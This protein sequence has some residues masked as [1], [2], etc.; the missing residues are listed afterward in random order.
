MDSLDQV[1]NEGYGEAAKYYHEER[2]EE[3]IEKNT[4]E[5]LNDPAVPLYPRIKLL[6]LP[7]AVAEDWSE[8]NDCCV[9]AEGLR[10]M[11]RNWNSVG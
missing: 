8:A 7:G 3:C 9:N 5:L 1:F 11:V 4:C 2:L 6:I 10:R